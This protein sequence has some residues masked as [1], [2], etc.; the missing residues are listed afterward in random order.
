QLAGTTVSRA[1][2]HNPD[3]LKDKDI[4]LGDT[5]LLHKA[6]DIIPEISRV[7]LNKRPVDSQ[8]YEI[9]TLCPVCQ[10]KLVHL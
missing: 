5:V 6:G 9:P 3:Y 10:S 1:S 7:I 2:L 4:R 8:P